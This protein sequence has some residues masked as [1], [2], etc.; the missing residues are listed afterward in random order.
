MNAICSVP[1][2]K[3]QHHVVVILTDEPEICVSY[4]LPCVVCFIICFRPVIS[5]WNLKRCFVCV[6]YVVVTVVSFVGY[7]ATPRK[8]RCIIKLLSGNYFS[9]S[10]TRPPATMKRKTS[11][12]DVC[13][14]CGT[15]RPELTGETLNM[16]Q[17]SSCDRIRPANVVVIVLCIHKPCA[18][19]FWTTTT[20]TT[21][22]EQQHH[23][24]SETTVDRR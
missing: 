22:F 9:L 4:E 2:L 20:T 5:C 15:C 8:C 24:P 21:R 3:C 19:G 17:A 7:V 14:W 10:N 6:I 16:F 12:C 18:I 23:Q 1:Q 13:V 11:H